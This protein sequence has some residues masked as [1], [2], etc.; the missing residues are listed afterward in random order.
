MDIT[1]MIG[2]RT[3]YNFWGLASA[4]NILSEP[5]GLHITNATVGQISE[6]KDITTSI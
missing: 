2:N 5:R 4:T 6:L 1:L 3:K